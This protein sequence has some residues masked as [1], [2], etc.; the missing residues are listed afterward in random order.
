MANECEPKPI[1]AS[2]VLLSLDVQLLVDAEEDLVQPLNRSEQI[3][4]NVTPEELQ[5]IAQGDLE[6][7]RGDESS[8]RL[9]I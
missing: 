2:K 9:I 4:E 1:E 6:K 3:I 8:D 7:P 5:M